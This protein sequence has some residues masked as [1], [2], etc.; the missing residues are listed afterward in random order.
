MLER[1]GQAVADWLS[2]W[3]AELK[4][5]QELTFAA[6]RELLRRLGVEVTV[7][8]VG[9]G[10]L[11]YEIALNL[12]LDIRETLRRDPEGDFVSWSEEDERDY[13]RWV[14]LYERSEPLPD[15]AHCSHPPRGTP[16]GLSFPGPCAGRPKCLRLV[17]TD[18]E[19]QIASDAEVDASKVRD[20]AAWCQT[21]ASNIDTL[22]YDERRLAL[23]ALGVQVRVW[24]LDTVSSDGVPLPRWE[25]EMKPAPSSEPVVLRSTRAR[26]P[27][28]SGTHGPHRRGCRG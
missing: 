1:R 3:S 10:L 20:L 7:A 6:R 19:G 24:R 18:V 27:Q 5:V 16:S 28:C 2:V 9:S 13:E 22:T 4:R 23:T 15:T 11:R 12:P 21:V 17:R 25:I 8:K 26:F 14:S